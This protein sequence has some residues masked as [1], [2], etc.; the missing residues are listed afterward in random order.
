MGPLPKLRWRFFALLHKFHCTITEMILYDRMVCMP[1]LYEGVAYTCIFALVFAAWILAVVLKVFLIWLCARNCFV[2][3]QH[4]SSKSK[5]LIIMSYIGPWSALLFLNTLQEQ[6]CS[7]TGILFQLQ[8]KILVQGV[9]SS[10][11]FH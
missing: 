4:M 3:F 10:Q 8:F 11:V 9:F 2:A 5:N 7:K 6:C 1:P